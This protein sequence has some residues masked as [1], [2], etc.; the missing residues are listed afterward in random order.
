[1]CRTTSAQQSGHS[2]TSDTVVSVADD[3]KALDSQSQIERFVCDVSVGNF[4]SNVSSMQFAALGNGRVMLWSNSTGA[5]CGAALGGQEIQC[6]AYSATTQPQFI[7]E[8]A[9]EHCRGCRCTPRCA[10]SKNAAYAVRCCADA[11]L[12]R[13]KPNVTNA[14]TTQLAVTPVVEIAGMRLMSMCTVLVDSL[15]CNRKVALSCNQI[16]GSLRQLR[17]TSWGYEQC[18]R[19]C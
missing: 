1:M 7:V 17:Q 11:A 6:G 19:V 5:S 12:E 18:H 14:A 9:E 13:F 16:S 15:R 8:C 10:S 3:L 4:S 2:N